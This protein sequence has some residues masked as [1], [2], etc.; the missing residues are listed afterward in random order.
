[1]FGSTFGAAANQPKPGSTSLFGG[2]NPIQTNLGGGGTF[3]ATS[4]TTPAPSLFGQQQ[5]QQQAPQQQG[6]L[7]GNQQS[8]LFGSQ[9][10][11][12]SQQA[13]QQQNAASLFGNQP[14][15]QPGLFG[16]TQQQNQ[17]QSQQQSQF[18][19]SSSQPQQ[20]AAILMSTKYS[21]LPD[22]VKKEL[23]GIEKFIQSQ[24]NAS[25]AITAKSMDSSLGEI[26][27]ETDQ[28]QRVITHSQSFAQLML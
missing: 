11:Q 4:T 17:Q 13:T 14:A 6:G 1:M 21:E 3:G 10:P 23:D 2:N 26:E 28:I 16:N 22:N 15:Q 18:V 5:T 20:P 27:K 9:Q 19:G 25:T 24:I 7:F 12:Q 8:S